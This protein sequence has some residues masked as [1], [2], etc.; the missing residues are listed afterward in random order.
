MAKKCIYEAESTLGKSFVK[1]VAKVDCES[2]S[3]LALASLGDKTQ[4]ITIPICV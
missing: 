2:T 4:N 3:L 1:T